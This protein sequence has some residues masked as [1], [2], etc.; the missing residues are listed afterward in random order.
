MANNETAQEGLITT[1]D[2]MPATHQLRRLATSIYG[3]TDENLRA[4]STGEQIDQNNLIDT[5]GRGGKIFETRMR[6]GG[7]ALLP[8]DEE[9]EEEENNESGD[10][11]K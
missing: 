9:E 10:E 1:P 8:I 3:Q 11:V 4:A 5:E 7:G 2:A 6:N